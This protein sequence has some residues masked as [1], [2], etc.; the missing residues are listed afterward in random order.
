MEKG[1]QTGSH[2]KG[3]RKVKI[4]MAGTAILAVPFLLDWL[5]GLGVFGIWNNAFSAESWFSF[6][7]SY[8]PS[9]I[10]GLLSIYQAHIIRQKDEEYR[11]LLNKHRFVPASHGCVCRYEEENGTIGRYDISEIRQMLS[12]GG[13]KE[14]FKEWEQGY[15]LECD[16]HN[17]S[18]IEINKIELE[19]ILWET[20]GAVY[21]QK[22]R[23]RIANI[24][25][26]RSYDQHQMVVFWIFDG[27]EA[28]DRITRCM[29]SKT[30]SEYRFENSMLTV[31]L[32]IVDDE[33]QVSA[34]I[35]R[36]RLQAQN[37]QYKLLSIEE[38]YY[39]R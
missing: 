1:R 5:Y 12:Q 28:K 24:L 34:L 26:R 35:M 36:Y 37:D 31:H 29:L 39:V 20:N 11:K 23:D 16:I 15:I 3:K 10:L 30:R 13:R 33:N 4:L 7:G 8:L 9:T 14:L 18:D 19:K 22:N 2:I 17:S 32:W 25:K 27:T 6:I 38:K 21:I